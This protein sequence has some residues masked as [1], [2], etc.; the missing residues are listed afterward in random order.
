MNRLSALY[1]LFNMFIHDMSL[2]EYVHIHC[3][4]IA[5]CLDTM[6]PWARSTPVTIQN[7]LRVKLKSYFFA[8]YNMPMLY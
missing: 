6:E 2:T 5:Y 3:C 1:L 7:A 8:T 4:L